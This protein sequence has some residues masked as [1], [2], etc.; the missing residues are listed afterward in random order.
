MDEADKAREK[1]RLFDALRAGHADLKASWGGY[2]GY[3]RWFVSDLNNAKLALVA[4]YNVYVPAFERLLAEQQGDMVKFHEAVEALSKLPKAER[5][6][7][8]ERLVAEQS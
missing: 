8:L 6:V 2:T 3:D 1:A 4:T 5:D 7:E